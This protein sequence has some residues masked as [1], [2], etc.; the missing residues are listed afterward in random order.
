MWLQCVIQ[1]AAVVACAVKGP[2]CIRARTVFYAGW[3]ALLASSILSAAY[4]Q[5]GVMGC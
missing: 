5:Y 4:L 3:L 1:G 2:Q